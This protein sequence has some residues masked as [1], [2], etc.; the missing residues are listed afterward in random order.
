MEGIKRRGKLTAATF[1]RQVAGRYGSDGPLIPLLIE[2]GQPAWPTE[3]KF[4][5]KKEAV[6]K[7]QNGG[8]KDKK[9]GQTHIHHLLQSSH[10]QVWQRRV[11]GPCIH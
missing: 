11:L 5:W 1:Y 3:K 10:G 8:G 2:G 9:E 7:N 6:R 4:N